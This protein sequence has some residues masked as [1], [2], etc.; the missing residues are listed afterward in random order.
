MIEFLQKLNMLNV[1]MTI[2]N[3]T[4][5]HRTI[6]VTFTKTKLSGETYN[7]SVA[8]DVFEIDMT[9]VSFLKILDMHLNKFLQEFDGVRFQ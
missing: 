6:V 4:F 5:L 3:E 7:K 8:I 2:R 9:K 1:E